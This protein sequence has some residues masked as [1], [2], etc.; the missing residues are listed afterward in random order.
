[1]TLY[2]LL[3]IAVS[4]VLL[5]VSIILLVL[6][7]VYRARVMSS[8][9][10][11]DQSQVVK[12]DENREISKAGA[13]PVVDTEAINRDIV[14]LS[15]IL[16]HDLNNKLGAVVGTVSVLEYQLN[17]SIPVN[18]DSLREDLATIKGAI[19]EANTFIRS[20]Q[21]Y[22]KQVVNEAVPVNMN[23]IVKGLADST[24][25]QL[26]GGASVMTEVP[27][28][29]VLVK[30]N[31][32]QITNLLEKV[33]NNSAQ[34]T[35]DGCEISIRLEEM[36][37]QKE[38]EFKYNYNEDDRL[39]RVIISDNGCGIDEEEK[40]LLFKPFQTNSEKGFGIG[41]VIV[42]ELLKWHNGFLEIDSEQGRGT[43]VSIYFPAI[44]AEG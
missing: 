6:L 5:T 3:S 15:R 34:D 14:I 26:A 42:R 40:K 44:K 28:K 32:D 1:M 25:K 35:S 19:D 41:L 16:I 7:L 33:C 29:P 43:S 37:T 27:D 36:P 39:C 12:N 22:Y 20:F 23:N 17:N 21:R 24:R 9:V 4:A 10:L 11:T 31:I 38:F 13:T 8:P 18:S 2:L 30:G